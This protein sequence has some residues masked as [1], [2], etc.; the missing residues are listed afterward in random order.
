[1]A[2]WRGEREVGESEMNNYKRHKPTNTHHPCHPR[3]KVDILF[4]WQFVTTFQTFLKRAFW[5]VANWHNYKHW[6]T[7]PGHWRINFIRWRS[8]TCWQNDRLPS[9]A[10]YN[11]AATI[12]HWAKTI[13]HYAVLIFHWVKM[14]Y[15]P[16]Q[17]INHLV[18]TINRLLQTICHLVQTIYRS[19][20]I[21]NH[22]VQMINHSVQ[23]INRLV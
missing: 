3:S 6:G 9:E 1:M 8:N 7:D 17:M 15:H 4:L 11:F 2:T 19:V 18:E 12:I 22:L 21:I 20:Q 10:I 13:N 14:I 23:M 16:L 5:K